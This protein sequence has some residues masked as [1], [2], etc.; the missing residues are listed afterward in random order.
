VNHIS[1]ASPQF[2]DYIQH[3]AD[4]RFDSMFV[5]WRDI[6]PE[7]EGATYS[8]AA[9]EASMHSAPQGAVVQH[10]MQYRQGALVTRHCQAAS[11]GM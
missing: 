2:Q 11:G 5:K 9:E 3:G 1:P 6:W 8:D 7:G 4:S 10:Y